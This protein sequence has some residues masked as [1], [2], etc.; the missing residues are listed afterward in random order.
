MN[1]NEADDILD[2]PETEYENQCVYVVRDQ[3]CDHVKNNIA[4]ASLPRNLVLKP[5]E[6]LDN[7]SKVV[8]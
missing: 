1:D 5:S 3:P 4:E 2:L 7:V 6:T 8:L